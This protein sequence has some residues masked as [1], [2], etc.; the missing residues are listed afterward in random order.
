MGGRAAEELVFSHFSTGAA[1]DLKMATKSARAMVCSYGM[2][3]K[4]GPVSLELDQEPVFL[5]REIGHG[6]V[7][8]Q[9]KLGEIDDEV[10]EILSNAYDTAKR[11]LVEHR[12]VLEK[13]AVSLLERET[14]N[15]RELKILL[16]G[17]ELPPL[18]DL[19]PSQPIDEA[20]AAGQDEKV[21]PP[22][23]QETIPEPEPMP[24]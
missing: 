8:S 17:G 16:E 15:D 20:L 2:S 19:V 14:L 23:G 5:G 1:N 10:H 9:A 24:G 11:V 6:H 18:S 21:S 12:A 13:I 7:Q 22:F 4:I 3:D